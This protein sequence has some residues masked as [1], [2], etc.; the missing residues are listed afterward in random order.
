MD[1]LLSRE[2]PFHLKHK[3]RLTQALSQYYFRCGQYD[4]GFDYNAASL[5]MALNL[6]NMHRVG[7]AVVSFQEHE[8]QA[9][10]EHKERFISILLSMNHYIHG[11]FLVQYY[12]SVVA[13]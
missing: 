13:G 10:A 8:K 12:R 1:D 9:S 6:K 5:K 4:T 11:S 2:D 3:L 7:M